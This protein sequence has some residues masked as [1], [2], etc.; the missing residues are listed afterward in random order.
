MSEIHA[1]R[2]NWIAIVSWIATIIT[3]ITFF[4]TSAWSFALARKDID[5]VKDFALKQEAINLSQAQMNTK[6]STTLDTINKNVE[7]ILNKV[8]YK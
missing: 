4:T 3:V 6:T 7:L 5:D 2:I 1:K 8:I